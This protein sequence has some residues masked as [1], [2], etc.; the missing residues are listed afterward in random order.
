MHLPQLLKGFTDFLLQ[1]SFCPF[2][3]F[4]LLKLDSIGSITVVW[5]FLTDELL[6]QSWREKATNEKFVNSWKTTKKWWILVG[7]SS[8]N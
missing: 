7:V 1:E 3:Y 8:L 6:I 4:Y 2:D 5:L